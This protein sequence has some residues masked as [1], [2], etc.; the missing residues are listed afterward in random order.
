MFDGDRGPSDA[1]ARAR[2]DFVTRSDAHHHP[3]FEMS[4]ST[5]E[6]T[7]APFACARARCDRAQSGLASRTGEASPPEEPGFLR[8]FGK[9]VSRLMV[10]DDE[11]RRRRELEALLRKW[12][13]DFEALVRWR[14][15]EFA[16]RLARQ[17]E[18]DLFQE[19]FLRVWKMLL[20]GK[21]IEFPAAFLLEVARLVAL[22]HCEKVGRT[23]LRTDEAPERE[24]PGATPEDDVAGREGL[25]RV[26]SLLR[27]Y[28]D[29]LSVALWRARVVDGQEI[30]VIAKNFGLSVSTVKRKVKDVQDYL[31]RH[32]GIEGKKGGGND[33][34]E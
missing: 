26:E 8:V 3:R 31:E 6:M 21:Q 22:E 27:E 2:D 15:R 30:A 13:K 11:G 19:V 16:R 12:M 14:L 28:P 32:F 4:E 25:R 23:P 17:E 18:L 7:V 10:M 34:G 29:P 5:P 20:D 9:G 1:N 24:A 33:E